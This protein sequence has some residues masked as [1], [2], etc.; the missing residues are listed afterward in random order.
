M[1][2]QDFEMIK[3]FKQIF[4][5]SLKQYY[6]VGGMPEVVKNFAE[7]KDF[8]EVREIQHQILKAYEQDFLKHAPIEI[9][10]KI[11][12]INAPGIPLK[13]YKDLK[14]FKLFIDTYYYTNDRG[15]CEIDFVIDTGQQIIPVEVKAKSL[16]TYYEKYS[17]SISIRTSM[18]DLKMKTG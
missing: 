10:P 18:Q 9:V 17:P 15:S 1:N 6:F 8:N 13:A 12:R 2:Q 7:N 4:I 11:S 14:A 16:K 5:D 3:N